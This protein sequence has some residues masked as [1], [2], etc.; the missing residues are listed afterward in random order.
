MIKQTVKYLKNYYETCRLSSSELKKLAN[1]TEIRSPYK[2]VYAFIGAVVHYHLM[3][4][5]RTMNNQS[6][7]QYYKNTISYLNDTDTIALGRKMRDEYWQKYDPLNKDGYVR[8]FK[9][10]IGYHDGIKSSSDMSNIDKI[11]RVRKLRLT[12]RF[13]LQT[14]VYRGGPEPSQ[15]KGIMVII[16]GRR[17]CPDYVMGLKKIYDPAKQFGRSWMDRG[18][19]VYA[20]QVD[21]LGRLAGFERINYS[22]I[23]AD[24]ARVIDLINHIDEMEDRNSVLIIIGFSWGAHI[25]E[26][27]GILSRRVDVVLSIGGTSRGDFFERLAHRWYRA[28]LQKKEVNSFQ[29]PAYQF[30]YNGSGI[31]RLIAPKP[32]VISVGTHDYGQEKYKHILET[33]EFYEK[34][35]WDE[36]IRLNLFYGFHEVDIEG[37]YVALRELEKN[38]VLENVVLNRIQVDD[39][40]G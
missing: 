19:I 16:H 12:D 22:A 23:G 36:R 1:Y 20:P 27:V 28:C 14:E 11:G 9:D 18:Y 3:N 32:L 17:S 10:I 21:S 25:A 40:N 29:S 2:N 13:G 7:S 38:H 34:C 5:F 31:F 35:G 33:V 26:I 4:K 37:D 8:K 15:A 6:L 24:V 30:Y 39:N